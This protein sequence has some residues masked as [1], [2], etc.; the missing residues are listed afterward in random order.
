[1]TQPAEQITNA[2][3]CDRYQKIA[4]L[5]QP[6]VEHL[7]RMGWGRMP[8]TRKYEP[9]LHP[10]HDFYRFLIIVVPLM[11]ALILGSYFAPEIAASLR[12][13]GLLS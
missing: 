9:E 5:G 2:E 1:M 7:A 13:M 8:N 6:D 3:A 10:R 12:V 11:T 4:S